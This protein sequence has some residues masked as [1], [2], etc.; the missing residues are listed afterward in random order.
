MLVLASWLFS[1]DLLAEQ[2]WLVHGEAIT[3]CEDSSQTSVVIYQW[4]QLTAIQQGDVRVQP[5][6][7]ASI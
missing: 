2:S 7:A 4:Y 3:R 1:S 6:K 5:V